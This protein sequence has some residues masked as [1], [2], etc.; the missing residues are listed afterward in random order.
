[1]QSVVDAI[2]LLLDLDLGGAA[3]ADLAR[4]YDNYTVIEL[5]SPP[6]LNTSYAKS[7]LPFYNVQKLQI[8]PRLPI[9]GESSHRRWPLCSS[10]LHVL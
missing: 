6:V 1:M 10:V 7:F 5:V 8:K 9:I 2:L 4:S 3:Y